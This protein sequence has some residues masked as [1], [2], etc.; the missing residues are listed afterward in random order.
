MGTLQIPR[1]RLASLPSNSCKMRASIF[2]LRNETY[3]LRINMV[4][5]KW[6]SARL[7][8][9]VKNQRC[10][11]GFKLMVERRF[12]VARAKVYFE[13]GKGLHYEVQV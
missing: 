4:N 6:Q 9:Y 8:W 1:K 10:V 2:Q 5:L 7:N 11:A 12:T 13:T 3:I